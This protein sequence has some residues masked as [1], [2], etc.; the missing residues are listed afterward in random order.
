MPHHGDVVC[1]EWSVSGKIFLSMFVNHILSFEFKICMFVLE[2][3][4][5]NSATLPSGMF[6]FL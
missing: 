1:L 4:W 2:P 3:K 5:I 6:Y